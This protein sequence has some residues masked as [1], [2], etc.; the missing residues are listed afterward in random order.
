MRLLC[1]A[2]LLMLGGCHIP[3]ALATAGLGAATAGFNLDTKLAQA[4]I[5]AR[6]PDPAQAPATP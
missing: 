1:L 4:Y 2:A 6:A 5:D 3:L